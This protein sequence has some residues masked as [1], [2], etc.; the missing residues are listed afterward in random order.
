LGGLVTFPE[1]E[2]D[3]ALQPEGLSTAEWFTK[4]GLCL[5]DEVSRRARTSGDQ[6]G[7]GGVQ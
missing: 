7:L 2:L 3:G 1:C 5:P 6:L 4:P